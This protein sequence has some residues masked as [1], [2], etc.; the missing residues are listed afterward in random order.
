MFELL[1][2]AI[3]ALATAA[4]L[5]VAAHQIEPVINRI[6]RYLTYVATGLIVFV[7]NNGSTSRV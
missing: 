3:G 1:Y 6:E 7:M 2:V 4:V 5:T